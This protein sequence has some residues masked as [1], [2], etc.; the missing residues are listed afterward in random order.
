M[1]KWEVIPSIIMKDYVT[2]QGHKTCYHHGFALTKT[3]TQKCF[4]LYG[5][6]SIIFCNLERL[7]TCLWY[8]IPQREQHGPVVLWLAGLRLISSHNWKT[9]STCNNN[10]TLK[11][12]KADMVF[13]KIA[14]NHRIRI[15]ITSCLLLLLDHDL[16]VVLYLPVMF[17]LFMAL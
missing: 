8:I 10:L 14:T 5:H 6:I 12:M 7:E 11:S 15:L 4:N 1:Y 13:T 17:N 2:W 3:L 16:I 9:E